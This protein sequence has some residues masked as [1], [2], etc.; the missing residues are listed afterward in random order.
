[1]VGFELVVW[2][3]AW[4]QLDLEVEVS[5]EH[6]PIEESWVEHQHESDQQQRSNAALLQ[7]DGASA[8]SGHLLLRT[9]LIRTKNKPLYR[10]VFSLPPQPEAA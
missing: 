8:A 5:F 1:M 10:M 2:W 7:S 9:Q 3:E 4:D 6:A